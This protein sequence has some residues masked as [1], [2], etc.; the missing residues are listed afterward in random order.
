[1]NS[2]QT[3]KTPD[4]KNIGFY[5]DNAPLKA[6]ICEARG[7]FNTDLCVNGPAFVSSTQRSILRARASEAFKRA[8]ID[9]GF[10]QSK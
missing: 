2:T 7:L 1:M 9:H 3:V 5:N 10:G 6:V 8:C 4:P